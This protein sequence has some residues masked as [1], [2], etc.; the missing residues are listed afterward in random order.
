MLSF[1]QHVRLMPALATK[2]NLLL[3]DFVLEDAFAQTKDEATL[4]FSKNNEQL[5]IKLNTSAKSGLLFFYEHK[6][7][8]N[9]AVYPLFKQLLNAKVQHVF[10]HQNNRSFALEFSNGLQLVFK[11]YGP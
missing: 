11:L 3:K 8:R 10:A 2:L 9:N 7:D 5:T 1:H 6:V 4:V